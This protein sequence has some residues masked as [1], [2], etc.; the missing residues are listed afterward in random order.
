MSLVGSAVRFFVRL[1]AA[2]VCVFSC[3]ALVG[4][5]APAWAGVRLEVPS[6]VSRGNAFFVR[7]V[8]DEP[9]DSVQLTWGAMELSVAPRAVD[10]GWEALAMLGTGCDAKPGTGRV[11]AHVA[12]QTGEFDLAGPVRIASRNFPVQRLKVAH[13]M[14]HL[15]K[16][17]LERHYREKAAFMKALRLVTPE[18]SWDGTFVRPVSGGVSSAYGLRRVFNGE[19]RRP[20]MGLDLR[21]RTGTP[22]KATAPGVVVLA[23][24]HYFAGNVVYV[25]HGLG[26]VSMYCHLSAIDVKPGQ[27]VQAGQ[28]LGEIGATGRVTGPHLHFGLAVL[29]QYVDPLPLLKG[30]IGPQGD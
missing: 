10:G 29:G 19:P 18:R 20:H 8:S 26:V 11:R 28:K 6:E 4:P 1:I 24:N 5:A 30:A 9:L 14:V 22:V 23:A 13:K 16:A 17:Q 3:V 2:L 21:G 12:S 27:T 15:N 7:V 25:D